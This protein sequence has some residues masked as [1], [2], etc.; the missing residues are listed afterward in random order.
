MAG[1]SGGVAGG[2]GDIPAETL[3]SIANDA[4]HAIDR[5]ALKSLV[6]AGALQPGRQVHVR[7]QP[8]SRTMYPAAA[9]AQLLL[10]L[11]LR[12]QERPFKSVALRLPRFCGVSP[13]LSVFSGRRERR[14]RMPARWNLR[15]RF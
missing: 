10:V 3:L 11:S 8:G 9:A 14:T 7:G 13:S 1:A 12:E 15:G 5:P 2:D 4:T 6:R